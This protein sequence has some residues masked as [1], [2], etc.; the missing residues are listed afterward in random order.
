[1]ATY[2]IYLDHMKDIYMDILMNHSMESLE[3]VTSHGNL[4]GVFDV[5]FPGQVH[6]NGMGYSVEDS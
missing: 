1:M 6:W 5:I 4:D 3:D 2:P